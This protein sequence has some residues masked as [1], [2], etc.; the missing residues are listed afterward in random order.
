[1]AISFIDV[2]LTS[3]QSAEG[4]FIEEAVLQ[5]VIC[6]PAAVVLQIWITPGPSE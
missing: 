5:P 6:Q 2:G 3:A 1:L 4:G